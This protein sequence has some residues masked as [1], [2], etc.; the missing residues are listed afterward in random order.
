MES[1]PEVA[2]EAG[3]QLDRKAF[4]SPSDTSIDES[5]KSAKADKEVSVGSGSCSINVGLPVA[6]SIG[7]GTILEK[8]EDWHARSGEH[9]LGFDGCIDNI[10]Q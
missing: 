6:Q 8:D 2:P 7:V 5:V 9:L 4:L 10:K 3:P 1:K